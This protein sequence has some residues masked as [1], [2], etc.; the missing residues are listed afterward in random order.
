MRRSRLTVERTGHTATQIGPRLYLEGGFSDEV[1]RQHA[2]HQH[3]LLDINSLR[4]R[5]LSPTEEGRWK[6]Y[7]VSFHTATLVEDRILLLGGLDESMRRL[8]NNLNVRWYDPVLQV[9]SSPVCKGALP[10]TRQ[11]HVAGFF[12]QKREVVVF[13]GST[14]G[15]EKMNDLWAVNVDKMEFYRRSY[16]GRV[17]SRQSSNM[18]VTHGSLMY[19]FCHRD[20]QL[21]VLDYR[22]KFPQWSETGRVGD[23]PRQVYGGGLSLYRGKLIMFGGVVARN[24]VNDLY[25]F[26]LATQVWTQ[27]EERPKPSVVLLGSYFPPPLARHIPVVMRSKIIMI[28]GTKR[29]LDELLELHIS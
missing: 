27:V 19:I 10:E 2:Q 8:P 1:G 5:K 25:V 28:G 16:K 23:V 20:V 12:E 13:G 11:R 7:C 15:A 4:L 26:D 14:W 21:Y 3:C 22:G 6:S 17:P 29:R 24:F 9:I 18:A